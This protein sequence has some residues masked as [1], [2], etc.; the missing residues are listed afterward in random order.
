MKLNGVEVRINFTQT[1]AYRLKYDF[2]G[3]LNAAKQDSVFYGMF[4]H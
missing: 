1:F 2:I 3:F 4:P